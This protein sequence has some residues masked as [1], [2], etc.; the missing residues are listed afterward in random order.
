MSKRHHSQETVPPPRVELRA[1]AHNERHRI[2]AALDAVAELVSQGVLAE[3]IHEP[4]KSWRVEAHHDKERAI[5]KSSGPLKH[6]K[7]KDW[8]RRSVVRKQRAIALRAI[9]D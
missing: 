7:T 1:H 6:W 5:R 4:G 2:H 3:D 9:A 8:K